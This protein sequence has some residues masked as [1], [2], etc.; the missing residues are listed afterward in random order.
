MNPGTV[1]CLFD[2]SK[3]KKLKDVLFFRCGSTQN[4]GWIIKN[5]QTTEST[6]LQQISIK[7]TLDLEPRVEQSVGQEWQD[8]D[9]LLIQLWTSRKIC[10]KIQ[11]RSKMGRDTKE[12]VQG[13]V[14]QLVKGGFFRGCQL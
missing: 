9:C 12:Y 2:L 5:L 6:K 3:F 1:F 14:P 13:L 8:L 4:I 11:F 10:P 7:S